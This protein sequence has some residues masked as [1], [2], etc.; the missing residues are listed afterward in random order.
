MKKKQELTKK[1]ESFNIQLINSK[2]CNIMHKSLHKWVSRKTIC[3][4]QVQQSVSDNDAA[5]LKISSLIC[6]WKRAVQSL[7]N[8]EALEQHEIETM[9]YSLF[10]VWSEDIRKMKVF[11]HFVKK[12]AELT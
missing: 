9:H 1:Q 8:H 5:V 6:L 3:E 4:T 10:K 11:K 12:Y 7:L 2:S